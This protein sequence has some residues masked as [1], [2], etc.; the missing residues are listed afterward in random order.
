MSRPQ[1]H[2]KSGVYWLRKRVPDDLR[3]L[4]G[5][6]E[7]KMSLVTRNPEEAK[8]LHAH[9][10]IE[11][12]ARWANLREGVRPFTPQEIDEAAGFL[13][14]EYVGHFGKG[15]NSLAAKARYPAAKSPWNKSE[16]IELIKKA[17][18]GWWALPVGKDNS[19]NPAT[20][21]FASGAADEY[22]RRTGYSV[23]P[24][25]RAKLAEAFSLAIK[26]GGEPRAV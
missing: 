14:N 18:E 15:N 10:L 19:P 25:G 3:A 5:K 2:P 21:A 20:Y 26:Y 12:E 8:R 13:C 6:R 9:A 11:I 22:L 23:A 4:V 7:E 24:E 17:A 1:K 16:V